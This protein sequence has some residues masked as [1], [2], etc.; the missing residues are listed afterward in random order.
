MPVRVG[1]CRPGQILLDRQHDRPVSP[2][3]RYIEHLHEGRPW[4]SVLDAGTGKKSL[5]WVSSLNSRRWVAVTGAASMAEQAAQAV[6]GRVRDSDRLIVGNWQDPDLLAGE[7]FDTVL[8]DYLLGAIEGFAPYWQDQLLPRL[9]S[10]TQPSGRLYLI[11]LQPYVPAQ[12]SDEA[13]RLICEIGRLRDACLLLAGEQP[14]REYPMSWTLR[15]L[16][17]SGFRVAHERRFPIRYRARFVDGQ[18]D[19]CVQRL[20][21]LPDRHLATAMQQHVEQLRER[22][23]AAAQRMDGL[24][25]GFDYVI[26]ADPA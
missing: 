15:Q 7:R 19:M 25:H 20:R 11:G 17:A 13:G 6:E 4:G 24:R 1:T 10:L 8:A 2:L 16:E 5:A 23:L 26:A 9:R 12:P 14:Y 22:A 3:L 21:R 18:L